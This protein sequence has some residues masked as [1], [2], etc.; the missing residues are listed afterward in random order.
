MLIIDKP[1]LSK[2]SSKF[3]TKQRKIQFNMS[4]FK[5]F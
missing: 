2:L 1:I 3:V 5:T 4:H